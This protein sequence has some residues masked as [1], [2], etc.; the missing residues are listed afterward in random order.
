MLSNPLEDLSHS[1]TWLTGMSGLNLSQDHKEEYM[2]RKTTS[3]CMLISP[4]DVMQFISSDLNASFNFSMT[5]ALSQLTQP[6]RLSC[7]VTDRSLCW[8][9]KLF[10][11][12][13]SSDLWYYSPPSDFFTPLTCLP[14]TTDPCSL[15][16]LTT[17]HSFL[18]M[19][20]N[21]ALGAA[22][23]HIWLICPQKARRVGEGGALQTDAKMG[24][25]TCMKMLMCFALQKGW[26]GSQGR[27]RNE[28]GLHA[29]FERFLTDF[30]FDHHKE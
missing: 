22:G 4:L 5:E 25:L 24:W 9:L 26:S 15:Q 20:V 17:P 18:K 21:M 19:L 1:Q 30:Q 28:T 2:T 13:R 8:L 27:W 29:C 14:P 12:Q 7:Q 10:S 6:H 16:C 3:A 11:Q 23:L